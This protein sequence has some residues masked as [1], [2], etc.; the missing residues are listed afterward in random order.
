MI[1]PLLQVEAVNEGVTQS[2]IDFGSFDIGSL[3]WNPFVM[4]LLTV[5]GVG[6]LLFI[7]LLI[8]RRAYNRSGRA[9]R[10]FGMSIICIR[11]PKLVK[12]EDESDKS[13]QQIQ[14]KIAVMETVFGTLGSLKAEKGILSW[15]FGREDHF[16]FEI[17][18]HKEKIS[19]YAAVPSE[20]RNFIEE[21]IHA[22]YP[23]AQIDD[24]PDYNL[25]KPTGVI[26]GSYFKLR[27]ESAFPIKTYRKLE[28][29]P[30]N[31]I[32]NALSKVKGDDGAAIQF[33]VRSARGTWRKEG[34]RMAQE[35]LGAVGSL[36]LD[37][38]PADLV[39]LEP[40]AAGHPAGARRVPRAGDRGDHVDGRA[41]VDRLDGG[42]GA[43]R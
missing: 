41:G 21:Q 1:F 4:L 26:L 31:S 42:A 19:F 25:F 17:V 34:I 43:R 18:A 6:A 22:Q 2:P 32:T 33:V 14:E 10:A 13:Q 40:A 30:L 20:Y 8:V 11:V 3:I 36:G 15:I 27:R 23:D 39:D 12:K 37:A 35:G 5:L 29:D 24:V 16:A 9:R 28:S 38:L 7:I